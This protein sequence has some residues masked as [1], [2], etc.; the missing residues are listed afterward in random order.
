M[1][2]QAIGQIS[3]LSRERVNGFL[4]DLE[5]A[6][7]I[8]LRYGSVVV[9]DPKALEAISRHG[10]DTASRGKRRAARS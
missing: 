2:Q 7:C 6:G 10:V 3:N 5:I 9:T 8:E 4:R 1:S